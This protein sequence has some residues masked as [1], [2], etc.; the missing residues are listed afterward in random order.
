[1]FLFLQAWL[2]LLSLAAALPTDAVLEKRGD[3][4]SPP[5]SVMYVQT[6]RTTSG[7]K[8][9]LL[10]IVEENTRA[11]H[12]YLAATHI[13]EDPNAITLNDNS[14][15]DPM[16]DSVWSDVATLQQ[17]GVKVMMMLGGAAAG[18]YPRLCSGSNGAVVC[19]FVR[20]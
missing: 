6:F 8:L 13:N 20:Y 16:F 3:G 15:D 14:P 2:G 5:R 4:Y 19:F 9:S 7:G 11:T 18:S 12:V 1:M 17:R 10:P